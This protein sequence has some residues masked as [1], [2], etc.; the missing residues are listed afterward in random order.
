MQVA[1]AENISARDFSGANEALFEKRA[2]RGFSKSRNK[3][4]REPRKRHSTNYA[5]RASPLDDEREKSRLPASEIK[6]TE[7]EH[8]TMKGYMMLAHLLR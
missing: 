2:L 5:T 1:T 3:R 8:F 7:K 4:C 6:Q